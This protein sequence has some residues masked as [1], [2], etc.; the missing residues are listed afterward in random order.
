M[1][2][3]KSTKSDFM[4]LSFTIAKKLHQAVRE[5]DDDKKVS[6][7]L[8]RAHGDASSPSHNPHVPFVYL[9]PLPVFPPRI[10]PHPGERLRTVGGG[11]RGTD[12]GQDEEEEEEDHNHRER[13]QKRK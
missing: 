11:D 5:V 6:V 8:K 3:K 9:R 4:V 7:K 1:S 13:L 12:G 10:Q 2:F